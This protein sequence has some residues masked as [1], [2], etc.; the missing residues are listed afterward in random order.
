MLAASQVR[1]CELL[2]TIT[3]AAA[4]HGVALEAL[5]AEQ[6]DTAQA[7][8]TRL[9]CLRADLDAI[10]SNQIDTARASILSGTDAQC[11]E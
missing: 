8:P 2:T 7:V 6:K 10:L 4:S 1:L 11:A 9:A 5:R 3:M